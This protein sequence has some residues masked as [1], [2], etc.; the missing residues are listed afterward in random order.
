MQTFLP[1][2]D[3]KENAKCLDRL[4]LGKQRVEARDILVVLL[5]RPSWCSE[6][7]YNYLIS[8]Y[9]N[10]PAVLQYK[11]NELFL[12]HYLRYIC[13]EWV[14]RGY[15][16]NCFLQAAEACQSILEGKNPFDLIGVIPPY[17][18]NDGFRARHRAALLYK[19]IRHYKQFCW[20]ERP[21][22][23]YYWP[24]DKN[25]VDYCIKEQKLFIENFNKPKENKLLISAENL[26]KLRNKLRA[27][28]PGNLT[29]VDTN[30][31][32][33]TITNTNINTAIID[34]DFDC[35]MQSLC[36]DTNTD[37]DYPPF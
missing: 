14:N 31:G 30:Y 13:D 5:G 26:E 27:F 28:C 6:K 37:S 7:Q 8:R 32:P 10:H 36:F 22:I 23:C 21:E 19:D 12:L 11:G 16:E 18:L 24:V 3:L 9:K 4:R 33:Y 34:S 29:A 20:R 35:Y 25:N 17:W 2:A 15:E 1:L